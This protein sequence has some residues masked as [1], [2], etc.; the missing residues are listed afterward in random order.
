[1]G[2]SGTLATRGEPAAIR[3][4][5]LLDDGLADGP[6][7]ELAQDPL[8]VLGRAGMGRLELLEGLGLEG[9]ER[10][11]ALELLRDPVGLVEAIAIGVA[12]LAVQRLVALRKREGALG[13][14]DARLQLVLELVDLADGDVRELEGL[15]D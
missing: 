13:L 7:L 10:R 8:H 9:V 2:L 5:L 15:D 6:L 11:L 1:P 4:L 3:T 14:S 12:H